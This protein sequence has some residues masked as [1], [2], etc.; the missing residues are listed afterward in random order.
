MAYLDDKGDVGARPFG[1]SCQLATQGDAAAVFRES[2]SKYVRDL[3]EPGPV[4]DR[5]I[6]LDAP[7]DFA[8]G[9]DELR[10]G[11][12]YLAEVQHTAAVVSKHRRASKPVI[13][14]AFGVSGGGRRHAK[15]STMIV[16]REWLRV[17]YVTD[18][19]LVLCSE[20]RSPAADCFTMT[21]D[22]PKPRRRR[23]DLSTDSHKTRH[24]EHTPTGHP[25]ET[26]YGAS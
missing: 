4:A 2:R 11:I 20:T 25:C 19:T 7:A 18:S 10:M 17:T 8:C 21:T 23:H 9:S 15:H 24:D 14:M 16:G 26:W 12:T 13:D 3:H 1:Q 22:I 5:T 6:A